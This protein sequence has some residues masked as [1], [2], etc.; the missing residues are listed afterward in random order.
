M[1][2]AQYTKGL[3]SEELLE[4]YRR[5]KKLKIDNDSLNEIYSQVFSRIRSW[6]NVSTEDQIRA[7]VLLDN[8]QYPIN[9]V[10][11][12]I[13]AIDP[14][15][16]SALET[17]RHESTVIAARFH[18]AHPKKTLFERGEQSKWPTE[19][20]VG[21]LNKKLKLK[22]VLRLLELTKRDNLP[23]LFRLIPVKYK[24]ELQD[25]LL[26]T[27]ARMSKSGRAEVVPLEIWTSNSLDK[28][29]KLY[30][31]DKAVIKSLATNEALSEPTS[32]AIIE[33]LDAGGHTVR[34]ALA[35]NTTHYSVWEN[36]MKKSKA[37]KKAASNNPFFGAS[38][39]ADYIR[40]RD[41][42]EKRIA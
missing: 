22:E 30:S 25:L 27:L 40:A 23:Q 13:E 1:N 8:E 17:D 4:L 6:K 16:L 9:H 5:R 28:I 42:I 36:L 18:A 20:Y 3:S 2:L 39:L 11:L 10:L 41:K 33:G 7:L 14:S 24:D 12:G 15:V 34:A 21:L 37:L 26:S 19:F 38:D 35:G 32:F 29:Q 31:E